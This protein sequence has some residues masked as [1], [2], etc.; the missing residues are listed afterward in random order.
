MRILANGNVGIGTTNPLSKLHVSRSST[1]C[2]AQCFNDAAIFENNG[3]VYLQLM[4]ATTGERTIAFGDPTS[5]GD[6]G[7]KYNGPDGTDSMAFTTNNN[8]TRMVITSAGDVG[9]GTTNPGEK[10]EV[11][12]NIQTTPN[13][14]LPHIVLDSSSAGDNWTSQG[15][16]IS[17][18]ESGD[19]GAAAL[20][21]TYIGDGTSYIGSGAVTNG[22]PAQ[23]Y[24]KFYYSSKNIYTDSNLQNA[25]TGNS[26][27][28]GNV[29]IGMTPTA[30]FTVYGDGSLGAGQQAF[31]VG[32]HN[33]SFETYNQS[34]QRLCHTGSDSYAIQNVVP[35]DCQSTGQVDLVIL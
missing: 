28:M 10:L 7:I 18:G 9:I 35:K 8:Q 2:G 11:N 29:G 17:L 30:Y 22:I 6:G 21:L 12:G 14:T 25:A 24:L 31:A 13:N 20:H 33:I 19:L 32:G 1:G 23:S 5:G 4:G 27:F 16:Y 3:N 26:Y 34:T 15:S